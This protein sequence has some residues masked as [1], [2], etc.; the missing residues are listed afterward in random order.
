MADKTITLKYDS[1]Q[2]VKSF[3]LLASAAVDLEKKIGD[4]PPELKSTADRLKATEAAMVDTSEATAK[5]EMEVQQL[6]DQLKQ[7]ES[8]LGSYA[9][10]SDATNAAFGKAASGA[11]AFGSASG[12]GAGKV[13]RL[14]DA[15]GGLDAILTTLGF[16]TA[17]GVAGGIERMVMGFKDLSAASATTTAATT[18]TAGSLTATGTAATGASVALLPVVTVL[19]SIAAILASAYVLWQDYNEVVE[20]TADKNSMLD[21]TLLKVAHSLGLISDETLNTSETLKKE[22]EALDKLTAQYHANEKAIAERQVAEKKANDEAAKSIEKQLE[23]TRAAAA[24]AE[25]LRNIT[26]PEEAE[27]QIRQMLSDLQALADTGKAD[28][29]TRKRYGESINQLEARRIEL[30]NEARAK[31]AAAAE[32]KKRKADEFFTRNK[33]LREKDAAEQKAKDEKD[34]DERMKR[35][36]EYYKAKDAAAKKDREDKL[37]EYTDIIKNGDE[38][39]DQIERIQEAAQGPQEAVRG[40]DSNPYAAALDPLA[41]ALGGGFGESI[42]GMGGADGGDGGGMSRGDLIREVAKQIEAERIGV[43]KDEAQRMARGMVAEDLKDGSINNEQVVEAQQRVL[44]E[45]IRAAGKR[46][47]A[48][49]EQIGLAQEM[50]RNMVK[51]AA[52]DEQKQREI[53]AIREMLKGVFGGQ[54][55][56]GRGARRVQ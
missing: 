7:A 36:D 55:P 14:K 54:M 33:E 6:T 42:G 18:A 19:G 29:E 9:K 52:A 37:A 17:G 24:Q 1:S 40:A 23:A 13:D 28:A 5:F 16:Q 39:V 47:K 8:Q 3:Q 11:R 44:D 4:L 35:L 12:E 41:T 31:E 43:G 2:S 30:V 26:S 50:A 49:E 21:G 25:S 53:A 10:A 46:A 32:E 34:H 20:Q 15:A 51:L 48:D 38:A 22:G 56:A 45:Q 27:R